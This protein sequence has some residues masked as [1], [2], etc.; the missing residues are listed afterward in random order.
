MGEAITH[1]LFFILLIALS[2][3]IAYNDVNKIINN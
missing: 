1:F 3:I 2:V